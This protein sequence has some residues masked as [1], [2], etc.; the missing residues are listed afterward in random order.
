MPRRMK[1]LAEGGNKQIGMSG[2]H[3]KGGAVL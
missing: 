1:F 3:E 2:I